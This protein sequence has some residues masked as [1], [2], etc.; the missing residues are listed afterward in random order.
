MVITIELTFAL[1]AVGLI[2]GIIL[3]IGQVYGNRFISIIISGFERVF[4]AIPALVL[5]FLFYF[6]PAFMGFDVSAFASVVLA[7]GLRSAAYQSQIFRGAIQSISSGQMMAARAIGM[8][9]LKAVLYIILPQALRLSIPPWSNEY[10]IVLKDTSLAYAIGVTEMLRQG[11][12]IVARTFGNA[13]TV[14]LTVA[15]I[16]FVLVHIGN[17]FLGFLESKYRIPGFEVK[18]RLERA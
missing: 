6:G 17:R 18:R 5:L 10:A 15:A 16:Y 9:R 1:L 4:R 3:S 8:S 7:L 14:Y 13:L 12:F 2:V 11:R